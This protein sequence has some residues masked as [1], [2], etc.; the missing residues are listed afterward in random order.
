MV[1]KA[2]KRTKK[3]TI[4]EKKRHTLKTQVIIERSSLQIIDVQEAKG[5]EYDFKVYKDTIG[6]NISSSI[7]LDADRGYLGIAEYHATSYLPIK[8][9]K[10]HHLTKGEK[11]YTKRLSRRR[12][13]IEYING[14]IKVFRCMSYPYRGHYRNRHALRMTLICGIINYDRLV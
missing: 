9:S 13:V 5:S 10:H 2:R 11:A 3:R 8:S 12:V 6:K 7:P 14:K 4:K 1:R